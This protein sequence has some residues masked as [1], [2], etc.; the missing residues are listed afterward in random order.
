M[1]IREYI[2][3]LYYLTSCLYITL[4][5]IEPFLARRTMGIRTWPGYELFGDDCGCFDPGHTP[6]K[7]YVSYSGLEMCQWALDLGYPRFVS[8][9]FVMEQD[10]GIPCRW[11]STV[12]GFWSEYW[13]HI[14]GDPPGSM[15]TLQHEDWPPDYFLS[16]SFACA[17]YFLNIAQVC[18]PPPEP[19]P[20]AWG[21][22]Q[23]FWR[24]AGSS[25]S[26]RGIM[27]KINMTPEK[28]TFCEA[29]PIDADNFA[30]RL[31]RQKDGTC[32]YVKFEH[33]L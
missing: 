13:A 19:F 4:L 27:E 15:L 9:G 10:A 31:A 33:T 29:W 3:S 32:I 21:T 12:S 8:G 18:K 28:Q 26:I 6:K 11:S 24:P 30:V 14:P 25:P 17:T 1:Y 20:A 22:A 5:L 7:I 16:N 23:V 2:T